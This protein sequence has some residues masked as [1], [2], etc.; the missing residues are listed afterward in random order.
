M[1]ARGICRIVF[2][3]PTR[4]H[5]TH[6][7]LERVLCLPTHSPGNIYEWLPY[8]PLSFPQHHLTTQQE[9]LAFWRALRQL[10]TAPCVVRCSQPLLPLFIFVLL[11]AFCSFSILLRNIPVVLLPVFPAIDSG[12]VFHCVQCPPGDPY[13]PTP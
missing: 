1:R 5:Q 7:H 4:I 3:L 9:C 8:T 2:R 6:E 13:A 10:R 12:S 11:F